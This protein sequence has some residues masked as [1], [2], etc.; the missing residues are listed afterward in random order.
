M[1]HS[2]VLGNRVSAPGAAAQGQGG[3]ELEVVQIADSAVGGGRIDED[4]AGLHALCVLHHLFLLIHIDIQGGG[5][6]VAAV[7]HQALRLG[8]GVLKGLRLI[9]GKHRGQ[10]LVGKLLAD[11][12]GLYLADQDLGVL[13]HI[14]A[15]QL[16]N[17]VGTLSN[18]LCVQR[19]I[20]QDGLAHLV[21]LTLL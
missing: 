20:D 2:N 18:N 13:R 1:L 19:S 3:K 4:T 15:R 7:R 17:G 21:N 16:G 9:H 10:L 8:Q 6:A 5:M 11:I 12:H 14:H